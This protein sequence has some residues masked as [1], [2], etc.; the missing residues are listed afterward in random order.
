[1]RRLLAWLFGRR[2]AM[3]YHIDEIEDAEILAALRGEL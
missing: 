2:P 1:M 3:L